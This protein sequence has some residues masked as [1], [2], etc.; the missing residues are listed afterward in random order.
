MFEYI[1]MI[2]GINFQ[3]RILSQ[4]F[5]GLTLT[6]LSF[7]LIRYIFLIQ[8]ED[9]FALL[10]IKILCFLMTLSNL[11][12]YI[13]IKLN[14]GK[15]LE[16]S[17]KIRSHR[18]H[19]F[20]K[21]MNFNYSSLMAITVWLILT[22]I[23]ILLRLSDQRIEEVFQEFFSQINLTVVAKSS[24]LF[25]SIVFSNT[26]KI[27]IQMIYHQLNSQYSSIIEAFIDE[28]ERKVNY[29][30]INVIR[31]THRTVLQLME[32][33]T[34]LKKYVDSIKYFIIVDLVILNLVF[35]M[36]SLNS[37]LNSDVYCYCL[38]LSY[39]IIMN[40]YNIWIRFE[41]VSTKNNERIL[42]F[43][44]NRW[45]STQIDDNCCIELKVLLRTVRQFV[46]Y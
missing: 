12:S 3:N 6:I 11:F 20:V 26:W 34:I 43:H 2:Y 30:D 9:N 39:I 25:L 8:I 37:F 16:L 46:E 14:S 44:L 21:T 10:L 36:W 1:L 35:L 18:S 38:S 31:M 23:S 13:L 33:Q 45:K 32:M 24:D 41:I 7:L 19:I 29:P 5:T 17:S 27:L 42:G 4:F 22:P 28:I 15:I 40:S